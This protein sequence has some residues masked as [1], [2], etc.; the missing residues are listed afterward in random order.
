M[1]TI[2]PFLAL[3]LLALFRATAAPNPIE[4]ELLPPDFLMAQHEALG[5]SETQLHEIQATVQEVQ[6]KFE[7]LKGQLEGRMKDFQETLHQPKP[8]IAQA[9]EKLR[10]VLSQ[11]NEMKL[12]QVHLMLTLRS[13]LTPEQVE[14]ARQLRLQSPSSGSPAASDPNAELRQRLEAKLARVKEGV[15]QWAASGHDPSVI[16]QTMEEK[17]KPLMQAGKVVEAEAELD[18]VLEQLKQDTK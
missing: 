11:E 2:L 10:A 18:R 14:K 4:G 6:P 8:D 13:K 9:E 12:L 7:S 3:T 15:Q 5:L 17:F 1:K 16:A